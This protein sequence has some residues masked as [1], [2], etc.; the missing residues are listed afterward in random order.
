MK[1]THPLALVTLAGLILATSSCQNQTAPIPAGLEP[2][3]LNGSPSDV[4]EVNKIW[5]GTLHSIS[6]ARQSLE[7]NDGNA[8]VNLLYAF[9]VNDEAC[10][11]EV[12][13]RIRMMDNKVRSRKYTISLFEGP[14]TGFENHV[15]VAAHTKMHGGHSLSLN[16]SQL[17]GG[18]LAEGVVAHELSHNAAGTDDF[19][20]IEQSSSRNA[21][22]ISTPQNSYV[23]NGRNVNLDISKRVRNADNYSLLIQQY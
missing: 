5:G 8:K 19:A 1:H 10:R 6:R 3:V 11:N 13:N 9:G 4:A 18:F 22:G 21:R 15:S 17:H 7:A 14:V 23:L 12:L 16:K 20:Y 2:I